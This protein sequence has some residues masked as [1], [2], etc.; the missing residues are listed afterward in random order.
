MLESPKLQSLFPTA[1][2]IPAEYAFGEPIHQ[3]S[4]LL[5]GKIV[6]WDGPVQEVFSPI[7]V[8]TEKGNLEPVL[9]G[10]YPLIG[11]KEAVAALDSAVK[12]YNNGRGAWPT[13]SVKERIH[14]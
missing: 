10:S 1:E 12:A 4:Y 6:D 13:M 3:R 8:R 5:D 2:T 14:C 11:E 9:L 7:S